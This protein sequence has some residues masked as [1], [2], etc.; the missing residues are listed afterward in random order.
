MTQ[1]IERLVE[2]IARAMHAEGVAIFLENNPRSTV[3][4]WDGDEQD[5]RDALA[6][7][8]RAVLQS[9]ALTAIFKRE[10]ETVAMLL[11]IASDLY[12]IVQAIEDYGDETRLGSTN[13]ADR[14]KAISETLDAWRFENSPETDDPPEKNC[15]VPPEVQARVAS[16]KREED[17]DTVEQFARAM[18][19]EWPLHAISPAMAEQ[20]GQEIG[21]VLTYDKVIEMGGNHNGLLRLAKGAA[22]LHAIL[23]SK[24]E[25]ELREALTAAAGALHFYNHDDDAEA[26]RAALNPNTESE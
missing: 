3:P 1:Q 11:P 21:S 6:R 10:G 2:P 17:G 24:R 16:A 22:K 20:S 25:G 26:A 18:F 15:W 4:D 23:R 8:A 9:D 19:D 13:D 7:M 12:N 5:A 14:L